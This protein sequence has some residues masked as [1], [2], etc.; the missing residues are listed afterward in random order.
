MWRVCGAGDRRR[1]R[2][3]RLRAERFGKSGRQRHPDLHLARPG[4]APG[5][6]PLIPNLPK[7]PS[8]IYNL[9]AR[10]LL[11]VMP[12]SAMA[13]DN[14]KPIEWVVV[15]A[16]GGGSDVVARMLADAVSKSVNHTVIVTNKPGAGS[17]I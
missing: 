6:R 14:N 1:H 5:A 7:V 8:M 3:P 10:V 4:A 13:F 12:L 16:A 9:L 15:Y 11:A 2:A 17:N